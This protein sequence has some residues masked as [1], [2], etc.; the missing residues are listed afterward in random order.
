M[1]V[2]ILIFQCE[3]ETCIAQKKGFATDDAKIDKT[4]LEELMTKDF[5]SE[6]ELL[7][8]VK[9]K[10]INGDFEKYAVPNY[11]AFMKMRHCV[12]MQMLNVS[13]IYF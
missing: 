13:T 8:D 5:G 7:A 9:S 6:P 12:S 1:C 3:R 11:C 10:C 4:K 2:Y